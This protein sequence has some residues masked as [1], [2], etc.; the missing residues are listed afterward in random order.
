MVACILGS[1]GGVNFQVSGDW[2]FVE[3]LG[4]GF[5]L[6]WNS[7]VNKT[8]IFFN[9]FII[10]AVY[11]PKPDASS[12]VFGKIWKQFYLFNDDNWKYPFGIKFSRVRFDLSGYPI[13]F[14]APF[15]KPWSLELS[16][17]AFDNRYRVFFTKS[18]VWLLG[19]LYEVQQWQVIAEQL[20]QEMRKKN[21]MK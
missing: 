9:L 21:C 20:L 5:T 18:L 19:K 12:S 13:R 17:S 2:V 6:R 14:W 1:H 15:F 7:K 8:W 16:G 11:Q 4:L 3:I 10:T